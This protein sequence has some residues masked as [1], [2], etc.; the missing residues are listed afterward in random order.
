M[1]DWLRMDAESNAAAVL[2]HHGIMEVILECL[3]LLLML[4]LFAP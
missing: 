2:E 4:L 1:A 3:F